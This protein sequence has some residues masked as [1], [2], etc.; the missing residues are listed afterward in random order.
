MLSSLAAL[1]LAA[2]QPADTPAPAPAA[3]EPAAEPARDAPP[4]NDFF[5]P[6]TK[7][8]GRTLQLVF[9]ERAVIH[10]GEDGAPVLDA[11][12]KGK[13]AIA[14][15]VGTVTESFAKPEAGQIAVALDGSVEKKA[16]YLKVWNGLDRP[17]AYRA[18]ILVLQGGKLVPATVK[19]C[20]VPAG[21]VGY[22]TWPRPVVAVA[23]GSFETTADDK[24]CR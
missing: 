20:A 9:G 12:E 5:Q 23:L 15:P 24:A 21:G 8:D 13:L 22:E 4:A 10:L 3:S 17:I 19:V 14:H 11:S 16:S 18:G 6:V 1:L 7:L 2:A